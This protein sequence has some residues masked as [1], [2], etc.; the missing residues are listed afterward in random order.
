MYISY[1]VNEEE[2]SVQILNCNKSKEYVWNN[3]CIVC[4]NY[5]QDLLNFQ[6]ND[7][8]L[9][10][11]IIPLKE[12]DQIKLKGVYRISSEGIIWNSTTDIVK[13]ICTFYV[14]QPSEMISIKK[15]PNEMLLDELEK[16]MIERRKKISDD[17]K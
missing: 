11:T 1:Y 5:K 2:K 9:D 15:E 7:S 8:L 10:I 17:A 13:D 4:E 3:M 6:T 12:K 16:I 14:S